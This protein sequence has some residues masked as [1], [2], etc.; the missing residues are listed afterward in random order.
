MC[1]RAFV[2]VV[3]LTMSSCDDGGALECLLHPHCN[4]RLHQ[5]RDKRIHHDAI[6]PHCLV[7]LV[8]HEEVV[9][10]RLVVLEK[11]RGHEVKAFP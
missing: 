10:N 7:V 6:V 5:R 4:Y 9:S 1:S 2:G 8:V 11:E 3:L